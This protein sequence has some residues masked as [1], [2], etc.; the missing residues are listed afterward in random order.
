[1]D[2]NINF[3]VRIT[4]QGEFDIYEGHM[5]KKYSIRPHAKY[6]K[7]WTDNNFI[8]DQRILSK[9]WSRIYRITD[10]MLHESFPS[11]KILTFSQFCERENIRPPGISVGLVWKFVRV[12]SF[13]DIIRKYR[14][15][16]EIAN[17]ALNNSMWNID[18]MD[19]HWLSFRRSE[20]NHH[21]WS[22]IKVISATTIQWTEVIT[23]SSWLVLLPTMVT[24]IIPVHWITPSKVIIDDCSGSVHSEIMT[25]Y[26]SALVEQKVRDAH[27]LI[28]KDTRLIK[29]PK[30]L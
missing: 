29:F 18:R 28:Q 11:N 3:V 12:K 9:E 14:S 26:Q 5:N 24:E 22:P 15:P 25:E 8:V 10:R 2:N 23:L 19:I 27:V 30:V 20:I 1:M 4:S 13:D 21:V 7:D 16:Y 6:D 17:G